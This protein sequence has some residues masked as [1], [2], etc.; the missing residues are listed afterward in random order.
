[1]SPMVIDK[2]KELNGEINDCIT[3]QSGA[4]VEINGRVHGNIIVHESS[5]LDFNGVV[6][7]YI[8]VSGK[9]NAD[10][11]GVVS[12]C[13]SCHGGKASFAGITGAIHGLAGSVDVA[14]KSI[15]GGK[16]LSARS[17]LP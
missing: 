17:M 9:S 5:Y 13:V 2:D 14:E 1:M 12:D 8:D 11:A 3:I 7:G 15:I 6:D 4:H 16:I 10:I